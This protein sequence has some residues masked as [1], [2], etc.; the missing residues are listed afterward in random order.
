MKNGWNTDKSILVRKND[1]TDRFYVTLKT[2]EIQI[3]CG[4]GAEG[5]QK[6]Y[7]T[8]TERMRTKQDDYR[9]TGRNADEIRK[10]Y[11]KN[12]DKAG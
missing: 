4:E 10:K 1:R 12:T 9:Y 6:K 11:G 7:R 3:K 5:I 8:N 2:D